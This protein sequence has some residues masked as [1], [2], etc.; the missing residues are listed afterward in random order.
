MK[1]NLD[2]PLLLF[3][4]YHQEK[5]AYWQKFF[6]YQCVIVLQAIF[7]LYFHIVL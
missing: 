6:L 4:D 1:M 7:Y 5:Y 3:H 2:F